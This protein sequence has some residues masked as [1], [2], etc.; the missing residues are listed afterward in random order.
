MTRWRVY[1]NLHLNLKTSNVKQE[2]PLPR[3]AQRVRRA[4]LVAGVIPCEY[5]RNWYITENYILWATFHSQNVSVYLQLLYVIVP[6]A[7][8][9]GELTQTTRPLRR[10]RSFKVTD[11]GT[12]RKP[13]C[14]FSLTVTYLLSCTVS[15]LWPI[16]GQILASDRRALHFN[17]LAGCDPLRISP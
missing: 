2:V 8:E 6:K 14:D 12:N 10:S 17:A 5:R 16:I 7:S 1:L 3:R 13:M 11:F 15:K 9:F 4:Y